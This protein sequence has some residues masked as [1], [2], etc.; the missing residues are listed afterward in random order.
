MNEKNLR[1]NSVVIVGKLVEVEKRIGNNSKNGKEYVSVDAT[2]QS[3]I[4]GV[5]NEFKVNFYANMLKQDGTK[6]KLA[7][8]YCGLEDLKGRKIQIDGEIRENRYFSVKANQMVSAQLLTGRFVKG[9]Q[10]DTPDTATFVV[11]GI[12]LREPVEKVNKNGDVYRYDVLVGV[13]NQDFSNMTNITL[14]I[15]PLHRE[16]LNSILSIYAPGNTVQFKGSLSFTSEQVV[17][18]D[19][20]TAFGEPMTRTYTNRQSNYYI[21][22]GSNPLTGEAEYSEED[23][24]TLLNA[25]KQRDVELQAKA[26]ENTDTAATVQTTKTPVVTR[27]Q[28]SLI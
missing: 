2:V 22:G 25:Y 12:Y 11:G 20:N 8:S 27:R 23:I 1:E 28:A 10:E 26:A 17:V 18:T 15:N 6:S 13:P 3:V 7:E 14:H 16:V 21:Q 24:K 5:V 4:N 9:V 19:E